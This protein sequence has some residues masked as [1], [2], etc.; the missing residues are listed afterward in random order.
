M[1]P[2]RPSTGSPATRIRTGPGSTSTKLRTDT[3][4]DDY[5]AVRH[6][7]GVMGLYLAARYGIEGAFEVAERG[8]AVVDGAA[9]GARRLDGGGRLADGAVGGCDRPAAGRAR[10]SGVTRP[11]TSATTS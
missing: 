6:A 2:V 5:N 10:R 11:E 1:P 9:D 7:G 8:L 4:A 3:V